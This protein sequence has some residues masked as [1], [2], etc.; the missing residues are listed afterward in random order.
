VDLIPHI[1]P[2]PCGRPHSRW[3]TALLAD[4]DP[5]RLE[6]RLGSRTLPSGG[7]YVGAR[8]PGMLIGHADLHGRAILKRDLRRMAL[9]LANAASSCS[10]ARLTALPGEI[11]WF[12]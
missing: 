2:G 12:W 4:L 10:S 9:C 5:N 6:N 11:G 3:S 7:P 1:R 8:G